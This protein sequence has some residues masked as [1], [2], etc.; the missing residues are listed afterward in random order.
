MELTE[1]PMATPVIVGDD[2][3]AAAP[4]GGVPTAKAAGPSP[5][6][7][8]A[9]VNTVF[10]VLLSGQDL[11]TVPLDD[12]MRLQMSQVE[13]SESL[14]QSVSYE[15]AKGETE[16]W[17]RAHSQ[18]PSQNLGDM[19][20]P[21]HRGVHAGKAYTELQTLRQSLNLRYTNLKA[22]AAFWG[23]TY[24]EIL[25]HPESDLA[26]L[27]ELPAGGKADHTQ[28]LLCWAIGRFG[29]LQDITEEVSNFITT[30][31]ESE[32]AAKVRLEGMGAK[33]V[34][35]SNGIVGLGASV[36]HT[37][38]ESLKSQRSETKFLSDICWQ[39]SGTGKGIN[40][41]V[42]EAL[43][44]LGKLLS[45][46]DA[47]ISR[48]SK[49]QEDSNKLLSSLNESM[50]QLIEVEKKKTTMVAQAAASVAAPP[51][52]ATAPQARLGTGATM[53]ATPATPAQPAAPVVQPKL[54]PVAPVVTSPFGSAPPPV[55]H[56][57]VQGQGFLLHQELAAAAELLEALGRRIRM[58]ARHIKG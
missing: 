32:S 8:N 49:V 44:S 35:L 25:P 20:L 51:K 38:E 58:V 3:E 22:G 48:Q 23:H 53:P 55:L 57:Q 9:E 33:L 16:R 36:R 31:A 50:K 54:M 29:R 41:S 24:F 11:V 7:G 13:C 1:S 40:A 37:A 39:L 4:E 15:I 26:S 30:V 5:A 10:G 34:E 56:R 19:V 12:L 45:Q 17:Q 14:V 43:L 42:K 21:A 52:A 27:S 18:D 28:D 2:N 47:Q 6:P 46:V